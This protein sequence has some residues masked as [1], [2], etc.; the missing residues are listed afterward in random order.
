MWPYTHVRAAGGLR[1]VDLVAVDNEAGGPLRVHARGR[2]ARPRCEGCSGPVWS[3]GER[4]VE[5]VD[6]PAF[7]KPTRLV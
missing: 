5:L 2:G 3:K 6:L 4:R 1:D 7:G